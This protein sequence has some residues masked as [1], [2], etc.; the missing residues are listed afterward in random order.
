MP[1]RTPVAPEPIRAI[2]HPVRLRI[3]QA[4]DRRPMTLT[5]VVRE[6]GQERRCTLRHLRRLEA[7]G[8]VCSAAGPAGRTYE[9]TAIPSLADYRTLPPA[10]RRAA[11]AVG[12]AQIQ[13]TASCALGDGGFDRDD[14]HVSRTSLTVDPAAWQ[15]VADELAEALERVDVVRE[16]TGDDEP[17][18]GAVNATAVIMLFESHDALAAEADR[19]AT[20]SREDALLRAWDLNEELADLLV[21]HASTD[22]HAIIEHADQL[23]VLASAALGAED[24][25]APADA[26][27]RA[28]RIE[29]VAPPTPDVARASPA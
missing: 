11:V 25:G 10:T 4:V 21:P 13:A 14:A 17:A 8:L 26:D 9:A 20:F 5:D 1:R 29:R 16:D 22:W 7:A 24:A 12:L 15:R 3:F 18:P 23:R 2:A 6:V 19:P 27:V 28:G